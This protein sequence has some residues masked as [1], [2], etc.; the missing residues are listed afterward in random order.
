MDYERRYRNE[1][2]KIIYGQFIED[3]KQDVS[4][5]IQQREMVH[6]RREESD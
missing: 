3:Q 4:W 5:E 6:E 2:N 1:A